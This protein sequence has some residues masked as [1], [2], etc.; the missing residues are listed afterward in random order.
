MK[1]SKN[2]KPVRAEKPVNSPSW[3]P[4][5]ARSTGMEYFGSVTYISSFSVSS[6]ISM[7]VVSRLKEIEK[8]K[9]IIM[10]WI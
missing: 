7:A 6:E 9:V 4:M 10:N 8:W 1:S 2:S 3:P 5:L